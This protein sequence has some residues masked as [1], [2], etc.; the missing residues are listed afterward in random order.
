[1]C[2]AHLADKTVDLPDHCFDEVQL[3]TAGALREH[4][5]FEIVQVLR[6]GN[7]HNQGFVMPI[8][9]IGRAGCETCLALLE[10]ELLEALHKLC[11]LVL[12][13]RKADV[14]STEKNTNSRVQGRHDCAGWGRSEN[15]VEL[16]CLHDGE[17]IMEHNATGWPR[18]ARCNGTQRIHAQPGER[19]IMGIAGGACSLENK[20]AASSLRLTRQ[21]AEKTARE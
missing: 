18:N 12:V 2:K 15:L 16:R 6:T 5:H 14:N 21:G 8:R 19:K 4:L 20:S 3:A 9:C 1:M 7:L 17:D 10:Q 13:R 11:A